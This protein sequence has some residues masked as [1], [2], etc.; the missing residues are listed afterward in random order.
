[1][2]DP[3]PSMYAIEYIWSD[4]KILLVQIHLKHFPPD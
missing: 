1:M 2:D 3:L 4:E